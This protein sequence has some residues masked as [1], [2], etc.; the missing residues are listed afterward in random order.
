M[1]AFDSLHVSACMSLL[2]CH[3][4]HVTACMSVPACHCLCVTTCVWRPAGAPAKSCG[5]PTVLGASDGGSEAA[6][7]STGST[8]EADQP[9]R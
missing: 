4:L 7:G 9:A 5:Q 1:P 2:V 3:C 6:L 8:A